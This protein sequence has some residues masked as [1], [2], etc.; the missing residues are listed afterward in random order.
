MKN[1]TLDG[2]DKAILLL[3]QQNADV[4]VSDIAEKVGLTATPCWRRIQR[5]E[6]Q[7]V[8]SRKVAL[9]QAKALGLTMT[10]FVQI[11]AARHDGKWLESFAKH[12]SSFEEVV[13]F[14]RMSG[15]YDYLL[16]VIVTDMASFDHFYKRL[17]NGIDLNDVTSSFAMEQLKY[18]TAIPLNHL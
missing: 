4:P 10:V 18:T 11:K 6:A 15:E 12:A 3:L 7:G 14:Y 17:V 8:I 9:L 16:K 5:L 13:E 1:I 2:I